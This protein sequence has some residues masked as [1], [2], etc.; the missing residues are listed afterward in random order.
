M[1]FVTTASP[2]S[3]PQSGSDMTIETVIEEFKS[4]DIA[5]QQ[6]LVERLASS[7]TSIGPEFFAH[8]VNESSDAICKWYAIR[9]LGDLAAKEYLNTLISVIEAPDEEV[10]SS[11]LHLIAARSLGQIGNPALSSLLPLLRT[12]SGDTLVAVVDSL[13]EIG[14]EDAIP[15]LARCIESGERKVALWTALSLAKIGPAA[16]PALG[17]LC[18]SANKERTYLLIDALAAINH[19]AV[20]PSIECAYDRFPETVM[21]YLSEGPRVRASQLSG[22]IEQEAARSGP[23]AASARKLKIAI[24]R[25]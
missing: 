18:Q 10:G 17:I 11:S 4:L 5:R 3:I 19:P 12:A 15:E 1:L 21:H 16:I 14:S 13:G 25:R 2:I 23:T 22:L 7:P 20:L 9:A 24:N 8:V 6:E